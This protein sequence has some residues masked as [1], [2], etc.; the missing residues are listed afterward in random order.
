MKDYI[1]IG[2]EKGFISFNEDKSRIRYNCQGKERNYNNPE[3]KVQAM[4]FLQLIIDYNYPETQI[5]QFE[6]HI[7]AI[8]HQ[9]KRLQE[10]GK[11]I[12]ENA[13]KEVE[14]MIIG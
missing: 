10:E 14:Q 1:Q 6:P 5:R 3:E 9:A 4:A 8:R 7:T 12:L 11:A 13:K 2:I